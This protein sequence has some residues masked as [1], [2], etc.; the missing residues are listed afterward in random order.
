MPRS[1][2]RAEVV[3]AVSDYVKRNLEKIVGLPRD[4][5]V[6]IHLGGPELQADGGSRAADVPEGSILFVSALWPYKN[7][8][9]AIHALKRLR[10]RGFN[11][12]PLVIVGTGSPGYEASLREL[13]RETGVAEHVR[14]LGHVPQA[15]MMGV[16]ARAAVVVYPSLEE[17]FGLPALEAMAAGVPLVASDN[18]SL[19]EVVGDAGLL[20]GPRDAGAFAD[21]I[22]HILEDDVFRDDLIARGRARA[23][24]FTWERTAR[25]TADAYRLAFARHAP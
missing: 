19:P 25:A 10:D 7:A 22:A 1:M 16:Y 5:V 11:G 2:R 15:Q 17:C 4:R 14:F 3:I 13:A 6:T 18:S 23:R 8:E 24:G 9:V 12:R 21:A 20:V